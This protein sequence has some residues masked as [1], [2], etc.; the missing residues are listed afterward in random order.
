MAA[1]Q[2]IAIPTISIASC[3]APTPDPS[4]LARVAGQ[5]H[6][7]AQSP[8]FFQVT[9]HGVSPNLRS[10]VFQAV[11]RFFA[12]PDETKG[13]LHRERSAAMRGYEAV[14]DQELEPGVKDRKEGFTFGSEYDGEAKFLHGKNQWPADD[15]CPGFR[16]VMME[17]FEAVRGLSVVVFRLM[18]LGL[19]LEAGRFDDFVGSNDSVAICRAHRYPHTT[20]EMAAKT[21]GIGAHTD[22]GALTLLLQDEIGGLEVFHR[23]SQ[24]WHPVQPV[25]DAFVVNIGDMM[26]RWT[27]ELYTSTL[28]RV[29][30]PVSERERYSVAFFNEGRLDQIV[31]CIP[32]CLRPGEMAKFEPVRVEEH[33]RQRYESSY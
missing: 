28:H 33:L 29:I 13:A 11:E 24:T 18:A 8:G 31:E 30:S 25:P 3:L 21:R 10:R 1:P 22:F 16:S 5:A 6:A 12:L 32:T 15:E 7:A 9:G 27:N 23:Q 19:G 14:G 2:V 4:V 26:E 20:P 17:Y